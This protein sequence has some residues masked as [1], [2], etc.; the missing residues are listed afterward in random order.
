MVNNLIKPSISKIAMKE[1]EDNKLLK[2][3]FMNNLII[4]YGPF[5][6]SFD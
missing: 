6:L 5:S 1:L 2:K 3:V 4:K